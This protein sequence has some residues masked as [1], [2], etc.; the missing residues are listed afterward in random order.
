MRMS[1][2]NRER[3]ERRDLMRAPPRCLRSGLTSSARGAVEC[4]WQGRNVPRQDSS[5]SSK[6]SACPGRGEGHEDE[7]HDQGKAGMKESHA[8]TSQ[9]CTPSDV[10]SSWRY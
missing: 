6:P 4:R 3:W 5:I 10:L 7:L 9:M 8:L 2:M 1:C